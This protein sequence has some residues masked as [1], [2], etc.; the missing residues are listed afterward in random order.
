MR[1]AVVFGLAVVLCGCASRSRDV[2]PAYVSPV[3]YQSFSCQQLTEEARVVSQKAFAAAK[4]QDHNRDMDAMKTTVGVVFF[5]PVILM[6][7]GDG[8]NAAQLAILK[9]QM[10]AIEQASR[11]KG[12]NIEFRKS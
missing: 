5:W 7:E 3:T 6:N 2:A 4:Q 9:G 12:C 10:D 1:R 11:Q 8:Q